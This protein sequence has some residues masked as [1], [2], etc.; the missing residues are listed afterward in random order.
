MDDINKD[1]YDWAFVNDETHNKIHNKCHYCDR[2]FIVYEHKEK[3]KELPI[4]C[5]FCAEEEDSEEE[6]EEESFPE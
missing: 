1:Y 2:P 6:T 4:L 3:P 5:T